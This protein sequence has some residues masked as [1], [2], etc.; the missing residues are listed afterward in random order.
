MLKT[1]GKCLNHWSRYDDKALLHSIC[2]GR[3]KGFTWNELKAPKGDGSTCQANG[4]CKSNFC[5][6]GKCAQTVAV[7]G[8]CGGDAECDT[9]ICLGSECQAKDKALGAKC[10]DDRECEQGSCKDGKCAAAQG[11]KFKNKHG[12]DKCM[13]ASENKKGA[14]VKFTTC[15]DNTAKMLWR[16]RGDGSYESAA[17]PGLCPRKGG[18]A[19]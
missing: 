5:S 8:K 11:V 19:C 13:Y 10:A 3:Y 17:Y 6:G 1:D 15:N 2:D 9:G 14:A 12:G 16:K 4:D 7:G 18:S